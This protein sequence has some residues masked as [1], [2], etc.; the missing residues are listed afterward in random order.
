MAT[1]RIVTKSTMGGA[2][3]G[4]TGSDGEAWLPEPHGAD[5]P[6]A[7]QR[8]TSIRAYVIQMVSISMSVVDLDTV[9]EML[10]R[11]PEDQLSSTERLVRS[12]FFA[13]LDS[14]R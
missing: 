11:I 10:G 8:A 12:E 4:F 7:P 9:A 6:H 2:K 1:D 5:R 13:E 3:S 14:V